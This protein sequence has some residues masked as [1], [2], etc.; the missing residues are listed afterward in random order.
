[1]MQLTRASVVL[2]VS[3]AWQVVVAGAST[4]WLI[5]QPHRRPAP[6]LVRMEYEAL[7]PTGA[8]LLACLV[9]LTPGTTAVDVDVSRRTLLLH[10]LDESRGRRSLAGI[11]RHFERH[12]QVLF[13]E[14]HP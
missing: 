13:P 6:G 14:R 1:M 10:M 5:V 8:V 9:T 11:R 7:S 4:A 3:F 12:L 2:I